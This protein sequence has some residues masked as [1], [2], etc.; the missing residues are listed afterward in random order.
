MN[1]RQETA[2]A[3]NTGDR[4]PRRIS[5]GGIFAGLFV[6]LG[7]QMLLGF[8]G[9]AIG[10]AVVNPANPGKLTI[11]V[12]IWLIISGIISLF[13]GG[14]VAGRLSGEPSGLDRGINGLVVWGLVSLFSF[15][16]A[17]TTAVGIISGAFSLVGATVSTAGKAIEAVARE[18][19]QM[20][21]K[22][23][24]GPGSTLEQIRRQAEQL[25]EQTA[26]TLQSPETRRE[27]Q[28]DLQVIYSA[29]GQL[30][31]DGEIPQQKQQQIRQILVAS[32]S[33]LHPFPTLPVS[34]R[35]QKVYYPA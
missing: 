1:E 5:W 13:I 17:A 30:V 21:Q 10:L 22:R 6:A 3:R 29:L 35:E 15:Y 23:L 19:S 18:V 27:I 34:Q 28:Q 12:V 24:G 14:W 11:A 2:T 31:T 8:L 26:D 25:L 33:S 32:L 20:V 4:W 16:L 9:A 7:V